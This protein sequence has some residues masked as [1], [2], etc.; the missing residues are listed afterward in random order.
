MARVLPFAPPPPTTDIDIDKRGGRA[1]TTEQAPGATAPPT[2]SPIPT[3]TPRTGRHIP[4]AGT[5]GA[6][7]I[8]RAR[9]QMLSDAKPRSRTRIGADALC[10]STLRGFHSLSVLSTQAARPFSRE[11]DGIHLGCRAAPQRPGFH[12]G[13]SSRSACQRRATSGCERSHPT[14][15]LRPYSA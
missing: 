11:R 12:A 8:E 15:A 5:P 2:A 1:M 4:A 6:E 7:E 10:E 3:S 13:S 14:R 9:Q